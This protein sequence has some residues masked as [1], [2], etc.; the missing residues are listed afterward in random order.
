M[1]DNLARFARL[2]RAAKE[3]EA[4]RVE[5]ERATEDAR[6]RIAEAEAAIRALRSP[7][8]LAG[9]PGGCHR[10]Y[11]W[12]RHWMYRDLW[13]WT[14]GAAVD[15]VTKPYVMTGDDE[16]QPCEYCMCECHGR[17]GLPLP[18]IAIAA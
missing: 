2:S 5:A 16:P 4:R 11:M 17:D 10:C 7:E 1:P 15:P 3:R 14:H 12:L 13:S 9:P 18:L 6:R 8:F